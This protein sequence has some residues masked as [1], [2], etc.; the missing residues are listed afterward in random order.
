M[1]YS[2]FGWNIFDKNL[3]VGGL[4]GYSSENSITSLKVPVQTNINTIRWL[5][6]QKPSR[7]I[8]SKLIH[9]L[10]N[11]YF[12][13]PLYKQTTLSLVSFQ[14]FQEI[15]ELWKSY[16]V[17]AVTAAAARSNNYPPALLPVPVTEYACS[18]DYGDFKVF[19]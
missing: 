15:M 11:Q 6:T 3:T 2:P 4:F 7:N 12:F 5:K 14:M 19:H 16:L 10:Y 1:I 17:M 13:P 8:L 9:M 18:M